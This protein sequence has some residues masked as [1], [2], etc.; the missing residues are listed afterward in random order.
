MASS[1]PQTGCEM[2][3]RFCR[4]D[5]YCDRCR[6]VLFAWADDRP[7]E[8]CV[9]FAPSVMAEI[10]YVPRSPRRLAGKVRMIHQ[11]K[12]LR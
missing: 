5:I 12:G 7:I 10:G 8:E 9:K 6:D 3:A 11:N 2:C 1:V 4:C